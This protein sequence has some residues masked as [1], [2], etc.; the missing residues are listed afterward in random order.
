VIPQIFAYVLLIGLFCLGASVAI[1]VIMVV[2]ALLVLLLAPKLLVYGNTGMVLIARPWLVGIKGF[3]SAEQVG[4]EL[5]GCVAQERD[6]PTIAYSSSGSI[7]AHPSKSLIRGGD[8]T[9]SE[10]AASRTPNVYTLVD[11][12]ANQ[13]YYFTAARPP[14]VCLYLGREGGL[15]R[16]A[17]CSESCNLNELHKETVLRMP[18]YIANSMTFCDWLAVGGLDSKKGI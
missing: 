8:P 13:V 5:Y 16:F 4:V 1:G 7:L 6:F 12:V 2:M 15:G 11:T 10:Y 3:M 17:L 18:S 14:T 9:Q